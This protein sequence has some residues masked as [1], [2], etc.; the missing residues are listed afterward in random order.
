[1]VDTP[2]RALW[3]RCRTSVRRVVRPSGFALAGVLVLRLADGFFMG[4]RAVVSGEV[5]QVAK[6]VKLWAL[7]VSGMIPV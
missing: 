4:R 2:R 1:M 5:S 6:F 7:V 3:T